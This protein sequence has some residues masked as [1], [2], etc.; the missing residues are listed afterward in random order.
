MAARKK[1]DPPLQP[2]IIDERRVQRFQ[3]NEIVRYLLERAP[4]DMNDLAVMPFAIEDR[5]QFAQLIGYSVSGIGELSYMRPK[6]MR[7]I[8]KAAG[9]G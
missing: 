4:V 9:L 8:D 5:E 3:A 1:L 6:T 7:R 2:I